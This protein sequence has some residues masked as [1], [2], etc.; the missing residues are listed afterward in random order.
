MVI[1]RVANAAAFVPPNTFKPS[2]E[3]NIECSLLDNGTTLKVKIEA[4]ALSFKPVAWDSL[5]GVSSN[6]G[7]RVML[8]ME[9]RK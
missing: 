5:W 6:M 9:T 4:V 7:G 8:N 3:P 2:L 1:Q